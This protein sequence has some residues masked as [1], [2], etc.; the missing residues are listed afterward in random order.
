MAVLG[1]ADLKDL[2][3]PSLWDTSEI[4][5][6]RLESGRTF[7]ELQQ[8]IAQGLQMFNV[9]ELITMS[10]Y[11]GVFAVQDVPEVEYPTY[12]NRGVHELVEYKFSDPAHGATTGHLIGTRAW[13]ITLGWTMRYLQKARSSKLDADIKMALADIRSHWQYRLLNRFF[14]STSDTVG[15]GQSVPFADGGTADTTYVPYIS[16]RGDSFTSSHNHFVNQSSTLSTTSVDATVKNLWE[17]GHSAP[18]TAIIPEADISTWAALSNFKKPD[19]VDIAYHS[20]TTERARGLN[21]VA[22]DIF[23]Y[24]ESPYGLVQVWATPRLPTLYYGMFKAYG[25][26]D[27]RNP[28]RVRFDP[29]VGFGWNLVPGQLALSPLYVAAMMAEFDVGVGEDRTNG[30]AVYLNGG[31]GG[32]YTDPTITST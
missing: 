2:A 26:G 11:G 29:H 15:T 14:K 20:S 25:A 16:P 7:G 5:K 24:Y 6:F 30:V 21:D 27:A 22:M 18:Y 1:V 23:G 8:E 9:N 19:W 3:L 31:G 13:N 10:N 28:L 17:H 4:L 32:S 12:T